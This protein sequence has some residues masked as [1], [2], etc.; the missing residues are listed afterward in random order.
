MHCCFRNDPASLFHTE[1]N[2][3]RFVEPDDTDEIPEVRP[4]NLP[5]YWRSTY[6]CINKETLPIIKQ[7]DHIYIAG[8][9]TDISVYVTAMAVFDINIPVGVVT[10]CVATLHGESIH[11][12]AL[13]SLDFAIGKQNLV[14]SKTL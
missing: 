12:S 9:F 7:Y 11:N 10:D 4:L 3:K 2:W 13:K 1:L 8:V 14:S 6:S 5:K